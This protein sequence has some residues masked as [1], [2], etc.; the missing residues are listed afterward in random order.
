MAEPPPLVIGQPTTD[1][2]LLIGFERPFEAWGDDGA[3]GAHGLGPLDLLQRGTGRSRR[4]TQLGVH[5]EAGG[6]V[7]PCAVHARTVCPACAGQQPVRSLTHPVSVEDAQPLGEPTQAECAGPA[8]PAQAHPH[9]L[10][11]QLAVADRLG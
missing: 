1:A 2:V 7:T 9:Q 5:T 8:L 3:A 11:G 4:K 10:P 6:S